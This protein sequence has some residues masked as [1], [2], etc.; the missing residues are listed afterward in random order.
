MWVKKQQSELD[1]DQLT[2]S[3]LGKEYKAAF[4]HHAYLSYM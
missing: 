4:Y 2:V 3:T 1:M